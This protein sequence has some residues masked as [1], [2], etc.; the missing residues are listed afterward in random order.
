MEAAADPDAAGLRRAENFVNSA[1]VPPLLNS[2]AYT[3]QP[4]LCTLNPED[5]MWVYTGEVF[6][7]GGASTLLTVPTWTAHMRALH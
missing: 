6:P 2:D 1:Q 7:C 5:V 4:A 3:L